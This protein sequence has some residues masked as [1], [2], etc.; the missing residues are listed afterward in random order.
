MVEDQAW[1]C[2]ST[3]P[4]QEL[5]APAASASFSSACFAVSSQ[6]HLLL[7][8][9]SKMWTILLP[10]VNSFCGNEVKHHPETFKH[11]LKEWSH[12]HVL[13]WSRWKSGKENTLVS[14][15]L[16]LDH[17][18]SPKHRKNTWLRRHLFVQ[19][20]HELQTWLVFPQVSMGS[21]P[22]YLVPAPLMVP[23]AKHT[24]TSHEKTAPRLTWEV[25]TC[26]LPTV[27]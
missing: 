11:G 19:T 18:S 21:H 20:L 17:V 12:V 3:Y 4:N 15:S 6:I 14:H 24:M 1:M 10:V 22:K 25:T 7:T 27:C 5:F 9:T 8:H 23:V 13:P 2:Q 16:L 26:H